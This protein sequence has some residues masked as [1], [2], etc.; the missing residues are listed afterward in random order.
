MIRDEDGQLAGYVYVDT[1]TRDIGGYV[2]RARQAIEQD[3]ALPPGYTLLWTGQYE[4]QVRARERLQILVPIVFFIIF[5]L[6][7]MTFH[8]VSEAAIVMLS[9]VYAM[10]GGVILQWLLGYN[11]S[12]AVWV[13]Y[14]ALYGV[15]VQTGV[16]MVVY[17]HEA[18]D[19][20]LHRGG[21]NHAPGH[22][23]CDAGGIRPAA[24]TEAD[25]RQ[26]RDGGAAADH[27][28][29]GRR[30]GRDEADC[31]ADHR[32]HGHVDDSRAHY[33]A[34]HLL[35]DEGA[36]VAQ[37]STRGVGNGAVRIRNVEPGHS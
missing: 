29:H 4:F 31:R 23:G 14:I 15:A 9:V 11:F 25:D 10:T 37:R 1:A 7:Y 33:H 2:D 22:L 24:S 5:I 28:E 3:V 34:R 20:R 27:V 17:L 16:V 18:L 26:R 8:S 21:E 12:V 30:L 32:R 6:L 35:H 19:K 13:G 36:R